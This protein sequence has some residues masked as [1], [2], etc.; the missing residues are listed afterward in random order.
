MVDKITLNDV[1]NLT[2][3]TTSQTTI[4]NNSST[5]Q[6]AFNNT[7]S[8]DG[9]APNQ[10][11]ANLD[12]NSNR[13]LN[14]PAPGNVDEPARLGDLNAAAFGTASV[15]QYG[16]PQTLSTAQQLQAQSN[17]GIG[18]SPAY[19]LK[20]NAT[21]STTAMG[22]IS[23]PALTS[24]ASPVTNDLILIADSAAS[25]AFKKA[26]IGS[27][28]TVGSVASLNG[29]TGAVTFYFPPQ[30]RLTPSSG[31]AV[32]NASVASANTLYYTP[33]Q[34]NM[35]PIYNGTN[36][37]PTAFSEL[38]C[39]NTD[40]T[41]N[42]SAIGA[43]KV[44][45][46]FVWN[47]AGTMRLGHGPDWTTD[48][49]RSAGTALVQVNGIYLNAATITNGPVSQRGTYVGT[50]RSDSLSQFNF[51]FGG[52]G[53]GCNAGNFA[54]WNAYNRSPFITFIGDSTASWTYNVANT[55]RAANG[56]ATARV[57]AVRGFD[58]DCIEAY[59]AAMGAA[60][61]ATVMA[62]GIG[63]DSTTAMVGT[64][65]FSGSDIN[66]KSLPARYSGVMGLGY[67]F[68]SAL[69]YNTTT[70]A[71]TWYGQPTAYSQTGMHVC[72]FA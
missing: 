40:T 32:I 38:S 54:I 33:Y 1:A 49:S 47:D 58:V 41:K 70:T 23:I 26:T 44:N 37:V 21:G 28:G 8:R 22:D 55:W 25:N 15:V 39:V 6:T 56:S 71:S 64:N 59:Y 66:H 11:T 2:D 20:G 24:K 29:Q 13:I 9:T 72:M 48:T 10:M 31:V 63:L 51:I 30:G 46:W 45:D 69:E 43:S 14:L 65:N 34:G 67:H 27:I 3:T 16:A 18:S 7:L 17:I 19:T 61:A 62:S 68:V 36:M 50:T 42:P 4:N 52:I 60:G 12:M 35:V 5:I 57:S 53:A